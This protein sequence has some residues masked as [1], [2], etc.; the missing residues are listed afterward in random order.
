MC[1]RLRASRG[2]TQVCGCVRSCMRPRV[3][4]VYVVVVVHARACVSLLITVNVGG[5]ASTAD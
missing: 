2:R 1:W 4:G 3:Q 5:V